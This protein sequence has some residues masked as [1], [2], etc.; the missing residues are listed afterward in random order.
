[1]VISHAYWVGRFAGSEQVVGRQVQINAQPFTI[2]GVAQPGFLGGASALQFDMWVPVG[3]Q[4]QV[5]PGGNRLEARGSR[6]L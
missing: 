5:S 6:W 4:P 2:V 3:T 1:M